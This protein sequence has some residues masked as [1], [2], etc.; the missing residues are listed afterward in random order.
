MDCLSQRGYAPLNH[1][2]CIV[3]K[4][5]PTSISCHCSFFPRTSCLFAHLFSFS[6]PPSSTVLSSNSP[7]PLPANYNIPSPRH[8]HAL[9]QH[10]NPLIWRRVG[11]RSQ[12]WLLNVNGCDEAIVKQWIRRQHTGSGCRCVCLVLMANAGSAGVV[13]GDWGGSGIWKGKQSQ[14]LKPANG[15]DVLC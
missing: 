1:T 11:D 9:N 15:L 5:L 10:D 6:R 13:G 7:S 12:R 14:T 2:V 8:A 4:S 3:V